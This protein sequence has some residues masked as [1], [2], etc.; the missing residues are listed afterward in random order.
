M[1]MTRNYDTP[2]VAFSLDTEKVFDK[3]EFPFLFY[4]VEKFGFGPIF[5]KWVELMY[6]DPS[7][8]ILTNGIMSLQTRLNHGVRQGSPLSPLI[9]AIFLEPLAIALRANSNIWGVQA[10]QYC[11]T[12]NWSKSEVMP[13]SKICP[14]NIKKNSKFRWVPEGLTYLGIKLKPGLEIMEANISPVIQETQILLQNWDK[15]CISLIGRLNLAKMILTPKMNYITSMLPLH[16]PSS[17]IKTY[18]AMIE[19]FIWA[20]KKT[21]FNQTKLYAAKDNEGLA[22]SQIDWYHFSFSLSQLSKIHLPPEGS[23]CGSG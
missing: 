9:F 7:T 14:Q 18:N 2:T 4:T 21:M 1:W 10:G 16:L 17:L 13:L 20:G 8:T 22:L 3:V 19:M 11:Y 6:T 12:V 5:R 23:L 15:L